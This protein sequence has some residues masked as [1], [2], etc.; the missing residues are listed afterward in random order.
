M[1]R[2]SWGVSVHMP[3]MGCGLAGAERTRIEPPLDGRPTARGM[4]VTVDDHEGRRH[5]GRARPVGTP[6]WFR[7]A[8]YTFTPY[9]ARAS[10]TGWW[11]AEPFVP[12]QPALPEWMPRAVDPAKCAPPLSPPAEQAVV[13][14]MP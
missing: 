1:Q 12:V 2:W 11:I 7:V 5:G 3:R 10:L 14:T 8:Q 4:P 13:R 6:A 9:A